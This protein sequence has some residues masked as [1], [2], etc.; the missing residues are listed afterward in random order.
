[1][2][3][4]PTFNEL[5][6]QEVQNHPEL[7]DQHHRVC[8]DNGER[9][10][11]WEEIAGRIDGSVPGEFAKKRW[12]QMRDRYRKELKLA[13]R[14]MVQPKW[15][16]FE[17]LTW[18]DP[19]LKD[20]NTLAPSLLGSNQFENSANDS[21]TDNAE[22]NVKEEFSDFPFTNEI[23]TNMLLENIMAASSSAFNN[24][25]LQAS[26]RGRD[27]LDS[28]S[29]DSAIASTSEDG[30]A[31]PTASSSDAPAS[32]A[33]PG[34]RSDENRCHHSPG[35]VEVDAAKCD[36]SADVQSCGN[37]DGVSSLN[38]SVPSS[39]SSQVSATENTPVEHGNASTNEDICDNNNAAS[40]S[41]AFDLNL[42]LARNLSQWSSGRPRFRNPPYLVRRGGGIKVKQPSALS[43]GPLNSSL[44]PLG[45]TLSVGGIPF[46]GA[47]HANTSIGSPQPTDCRQVTSSSNASASS[48]ALPT[49]SS[50][51]SDWLS[52]DAS[53]DEDALFARLVVVRLKKFTGK[54]KRAIR[55]RI[56]ELIDEKE[57]ELERNPSSHAK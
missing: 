56:S 6:I 26:N 41:P 7:Y 38:E 2:S 11:I 49:T 47:F 36:R 44:K 54:D 57:E 1:M 8:T 52:G 32:E 30:D 50:S 55:A 23:S 14:N 19:Y 42:A 35:R 28:F 10:L 3:Q 51:S 24:S 13:L 27:Q 22:R 29:P 37:D 15:P 4:Q 48:P 18:L 9:N 33:N 39:N 53:N 21:S 5:L 31:H 17:K 12:L 43:S 45:K 46:G 34:K 16:Y 20:S 40:P 25:I